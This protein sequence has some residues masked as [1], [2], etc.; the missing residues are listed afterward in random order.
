PWVLETT[1]VGYG[2]GVERATS[3][4]LARACL[5]L[6]TFDIVIAEHEVEDADMVLFAAALRAG[7]A[8]ASGVPQSVQRVPVVL[9]DHED[10][11]CLLPAGMAVDVSGDAL[12]PFVL[13]LLR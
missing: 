12:V 1:L 6:E 10:A 9:L 7:H 3:L 2:I 11:V 5:C 8:M 4:T 13:E